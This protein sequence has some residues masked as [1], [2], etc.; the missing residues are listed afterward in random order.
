MTLYRV[1]LPVTEIE[2]AARFYT[3]I[4][5]EPGRRVSGG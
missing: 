5:G 2:Q 3:E 1:I 4:L